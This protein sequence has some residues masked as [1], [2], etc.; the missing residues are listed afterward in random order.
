M[1]SSVALKMT[2][3]LL[4]V[5][6]G[7]LQDKIRES[8]SDSD[9]NSVVRSCFHSFLLFVSGQEAKPSIQVLCQKL[10]GR[11]CKWPSVENQQH[12]QSGRGRGWRRQNSGRGC[13]WPWQRWWKWRCSFVRETQ[14]RKWY[15]RH[16]HTIY[17]YLQAFHHWTNLLGRFFS[18]SQSHVCT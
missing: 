3:H 5:L 9:E 13:W 18:L 12:W 4:F 8:V 6:H 10:P 1:F 14:V 17:F 7:L 2:E 16:W 11:V 15:N